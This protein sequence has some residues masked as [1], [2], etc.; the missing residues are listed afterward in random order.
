[1]ELSFDNNLL[2]S[3]NDVNTF[4][5]VVDLINVTTPYTF[6]CDGYVHVASGQGHSSC[7]LYSNGVNLGAS[8]SISATVAPVNGAT[9]YVRNSIFVKK[10]MKVIE[11]TRTSTD[12]SVSFYPL[13]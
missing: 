8:T 1:M 13:Q 6:Q 5:T 10:G 4:G 3:N 12:G 11:A 7:L 2:I 9:Y